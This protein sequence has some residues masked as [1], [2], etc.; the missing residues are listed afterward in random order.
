MSELTKDEVAINH[1]NQINRVMEIVIESRTIKALNNYPIYARL[2]NELEKNLL[3]NKKTLELHK[4]LKIKLSWSKVESYVCGHCYH[5]SMEQ[6]LVSWPC[7]PY[8]EVSETLELVPGH[9]Q[10]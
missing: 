5:A 7:L 4:I 8:R 9:G 10:L 6:I 2:L 3:A 1:L